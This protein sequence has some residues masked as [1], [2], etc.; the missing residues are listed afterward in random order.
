M[1]H[2]LYT[3]MITAFTILFGFSGNVWADW[4]PVGTTPI[5]K[6]NTSTAQ[7]SSIA[8]RLQGASSNIPFVAWGEDVDG[9]GYT[10]IF[11]KR[12]NASGW[13]APTTGNLNVGLNESATQPQIA[14]TDE[15]VPSPYVIFRETSTGPGSD[16]YI[17]L[18]WFNGTSWQTVGAGPLEWMPGSEDAF[19][20]TIVLNTPSATY[21]CYIAWAQS[22]T[23]T[24]ASWICTKRRYTGSWEAYAS[25]GTWNTS[26]VMIGP[27]NL[28]INDNATSPQLAAG[29]NQ[30]PVIA[31][32]EGN[33][34]K[35]AHVRR[36]NG[37]NWVAIG[38]QINN[39]GDVRSLS[40]AID[41][42]N[43]PYVVLEEFKGGSS[44]DVYVKRWNGTS[45]SML[46]AKIVSDAPANNPSIAI[47][48]SNEV[49][50][51]W[52]TLV[53]GFEQIRVSRLDNGSWVSEGS[54]LNID[55][56]REANNSCMAVSASGPLVSW[57]EQKPVSPFNDQVHVKHWVEPTATP[58][59]TITMTVTPTATPTQVVI[60]ATATNTTEPASQ[61]ALAEDEVISF[62]IPAS[63]QLSIAF[64]TNLINE[65]TT[66]RVYNT[67]Y[68]IVATLETTTNASGEGSVVWDCSGIAPGVY[69]Y[70]V[71]AGDKKL[72]IKKTIIA[73]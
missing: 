3:M 13:V 57:Q 16:G 17:Y 39:G 35:D 15:A 20:P 47:G 70:Q 42:T 33:A 4:E 18:R 64:K 40:L 55:S 68:R 45:W 66:I 51:S 73:R 43:M 6:V 31:W 58:T 36:W 48:P 71:K 37:G 61:L 24:G 46:G 63:S 41:S 60:E 27:L 49:Y 9:A 26:T 19:D 53:G 1:R 54:L 67:R 11:S 8:I 14:V 23:V 29:S 69:F 12:Y 50:V 2:A 62:P 10:R 32:L 25:D 30:L 56:N 59:A 34:T 21:P 7:T 5:N 52:T 28:D 22:N 44:R 65:A 72:E 38:V